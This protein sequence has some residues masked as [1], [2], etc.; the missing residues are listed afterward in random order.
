MAKII[1]DTVGLHHFG[2]GFCNAEMNT[3]RFGIEGTP[4]CR[5]NLAASMALFGVRQEELEL[6]S[7][8]N[9]FM[10]LDYSADGSFIIRPCPAKAGDYVDL[11]AEM[12]I[13]VAISNCPQERN[14]C[15]DW[16][17]TAL[18]AVFYRPEK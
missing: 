9:F 16:N 10:D 5:S 2:G 7:C 6:D 4:T 17:P 14:P 8:L 11:L 3:V 12:D 1:E 15:N 13:I 18:R